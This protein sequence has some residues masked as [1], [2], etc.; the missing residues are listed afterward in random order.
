MIRRIVNVVGLLTL[1]AL[2]VI[3]YR[4]KT[5]AEADHKRAAALAAELAGERD[6]I[7]VIQTEIGFLERPD[8]LRALAE[9]HLG[10]EPIDP[11][12]VVT[13]E[14]AP[15]LIENALPPAVDAP[16]TADAAYLEGEGR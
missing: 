8:R 11:V 10:L 1:V 2:V 14:D 4:A 7:A 12:R 9:E 5:E 3:V 6:A 13:L 15:L 16:L